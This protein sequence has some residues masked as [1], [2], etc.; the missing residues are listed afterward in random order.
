RMRRLQRYMV[1]LHRQEVED[2]QNSGALERVEDTFWAVVPGSLIY[3]PRFG[4]WWHGSPA[5]EP[6]SLIA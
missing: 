1:T 6:E 2:L 4:F 5:P 3:H